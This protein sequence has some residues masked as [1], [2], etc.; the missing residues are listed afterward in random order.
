M[1]RL[2]KFL[3]ALLLLILLGTACSLSPARAPRT[4][5]PFPKELAATPAPLVTKTAVGPSAQATFAGFLPLIQQLPTA[6]PGPAHWTVQA[7]QA[8]QGRVD[9]NYDIRLRL[10]SIDGNGAADPRL[11]GFNQQVQAL[12]DQNLNEVATWVGKPLDNSGYVWIDYQILSAADWQFDQ[13]AA[14]AVTAAA[15]VDLSQAALD[16][17]RSLVS[18]RLEMVTYLGGAH[19]NTAY[20]SLNYDLTEGRS[21]ALAD[22]FKPGSA[23]LEKLS[24]YC[25]KTLR[26]REDVRLFGEKAGTAPEAQNYTVWNVTPDGLLITFNEYQ[27]A[28]YAAGPQLVL[29]PYA[30]LKDFI[31]PGGPLAQYAK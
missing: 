1:F 14:G 10:P 22:L 4:Q 16:L 24:T 18:V 27:V 25:L 30:R 20:Y 13:N 29:V 21:L 28:V 17:G 7:R 23:Y 5:T 2:P 12:V 9:L 11:L 6:T 8:D 15:S 26:S 31:D 19:P 3:A